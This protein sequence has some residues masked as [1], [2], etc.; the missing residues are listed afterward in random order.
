MCTPI[1]SFLF[2]VPT[3][4]MCFAP[5]TSDLCTN[6]KLLKEVVGNNK[7]DTKGGRRDRV[8]NQYNESR[9]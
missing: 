1:I 4:Q 9:K 3:P 5:A 8:G 2:E 6:E 7:W